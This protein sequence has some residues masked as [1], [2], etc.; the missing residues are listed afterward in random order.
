MARHPEMLEFMQHGDER[1]HLV[2]A[3]AMRDVPF[4]IQRVFYVYGSDPGVVRGRHANRESEFVLI[5]VA[6]TSKVRTIEQDGTEMVFDLD[7]PHVGVYI[8]RMVWKDMFGF[9]SDSVLL[10]LASTRYDSSE[11]IRDFEEFKRE[12][13]IKE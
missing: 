11:Y 1:G 6:G 5:N 7:R 9:S 3:E 2:V 12:V 13:G 4:V 10:I 8:P